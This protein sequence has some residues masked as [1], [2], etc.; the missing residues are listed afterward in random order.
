MTM[1]TYRTIVVHLP[2]TPLGLLPERWAIEHWCG[3]CRQRVTPAQ[4]VAHAKE[5][6][7][8]EHTSRGKSFQSPLTA[9]TMAPDEP[10]T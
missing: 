5:H 1:T 10:T 2:P 3:L 4:L 6:E 8:A 7:H 9:D